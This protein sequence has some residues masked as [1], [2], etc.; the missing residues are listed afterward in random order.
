LTFKEVI[1]NERCSLFLLPLTGVDVTV[2]VNV[3]RRTV[4]SWRVILAVAIFGLGLPSFYD[5]RPLCELPRGSDRFGGGL[6][7]SPLGAPPAESLSL[8]VKL[9]D[10]DCSFGGKWKSFFFLDGNLFRE[11]FKKHQKWRRDGG[12]IYIF[13]SLWR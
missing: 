6:S 5:A 11:E 13:L 7:W 4:P 9:G 10:D 3:R 8:Q 1:I 2:D 12:T